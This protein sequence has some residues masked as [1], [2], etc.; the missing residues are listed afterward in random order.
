MNRFKKEFYVPP[1]VKEHG[2]GDPVPNNTNFAR[3]G[4]GVWLLVMSVLILG[5][6]S[7]AYH[8][9]QKALRQGHYE[10]AIRA[11]RNAVRENP[12]NSEALRNLGIAYFKTKNYKMAIPILKK[13]HERAPKDGVALYYLG[14]S[15][16]KSG[17]VKQAIQ[18]YRQFTRLSRFSKIRKTVEAQLRVL[19][20][21]EIEQEVKQAVANEKSLGVTHI[22]P[23]SVA[24]LYFS[25][26]MKIPEL[27]PL[28][29]GLTDMIITD[30]SQVHSLQVVER[31]RL[32]ALMQEIGL[33]QTGLVDPKTAPKVGKLLGVSSLVNG[34]FLT[35]SGQKIQLEY[36]ISRAAD[37]RVEKNGKLNGNLRQIFEIEKKLVFDVI[38]DMGIQLTDQE[39]EA[40][41][42]IPTENLMAFI[43]YSKALDY[44]DQGKFD[45]AKQ[46]YQK[47]VR[48]D[49]HFEKAQIGL[50]STE[51]SLGE[52][53]PIQQ[54]EIELSEAVALPAETVA[55]SSTLE[56]TAPAVETED[57]V[58]DRV[59]R[60]AE[61][62]GVGFVPGVEQRKPV[63][64]SSGSEPVLGAAK[65]KI[66]VPIP[67][68]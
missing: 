53:D 42:K 36:A 31:V 6:A 41:R 44:E 8:T 4:L 52:T 55:A 57:V 26:M 48:L 40:I 64:E 1:F 27:D 33:G 58:I 51:I 9:G 10:E 22:S 45:L 38:G 67:V 47:A 24:V 20:R 19:L 28:Q 35:L 3:R 7:S 32:Q 66:K 18:T 11:F 12:Q 60:S 2:K 68:E 34:A 49:P 23:H 63:Q 50:E 65:V 13:V 30:L 59:T 15:F 17:Q 43:A 62:V 46:Q 54:A 39:R 16:E 37:A 61:N 5:C 25:N 29:K 14:A 21:K 56:K